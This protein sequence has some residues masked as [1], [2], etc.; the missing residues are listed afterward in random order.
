MCFW[1]K[2]QKET[3]VEAPVEDNEEEQFDVPF[4]T[5]DMVP[6]APPTLEELKPDVKPE[7]FAVYT[8]EENS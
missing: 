4:F 6:V 2:K 5:S 7:D 8:G 1:K 3:A